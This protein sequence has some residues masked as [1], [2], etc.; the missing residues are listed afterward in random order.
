MPEPLDDSNNT[1]DDSCNKFY[2]NISFE[3]IDRRKKDF[4]ET[5]CN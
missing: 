5:M 1:I 4:D 2:S 3:V